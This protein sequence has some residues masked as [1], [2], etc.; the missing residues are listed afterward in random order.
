MT[1]TA[2]ALIAI[3][4]LPRHLRPALRRRGVN[5]RAL[6][7][8]VWRAGGSRTGPPST[9]P[10]RP[11]ATSPPPAFACRF[12]GVLLGGE[13]PAPHRYGAPDA[14]RWRSHD[15]DDL[16]D[17]CVR[18]RSVARQALAGGLPLLAICRRG[19]QVVNTVLGGT[20]HQDMGG[21]APRTP[22]R[23]AS[24]LG[25]LAPGSAP[26][27][28]TATDKTE[29]CYHHSAADRLGRGLHRSPGPPTKRSR[30]NSPTPVPCFVAVQ[31]TE[32]TAH[33]D[34]PAALRRPRWGGQH[35]LTSSRGSAQL[36]A[37]LAR[38]RRPR[39]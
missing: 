31:G 37:C 6:I 3:R 21:L 28:I 9:P 26:A 13:H 7:E 4:P 30:S 11:T 23:P 22:A 15:V 16:Q 29:G 24:R 27:R 5:A 19:L 17:A 34:R 2:R 8:A 25:T 35:P 14:H 10:T 39:R 12:D 38:R 33:E 32:D 18:L 36:D 1:T 20:L